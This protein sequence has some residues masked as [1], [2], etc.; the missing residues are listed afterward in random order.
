MSF[1]SCLLAM[2]WHCLPNATPTQVIFL[3]ISSLLVQT[4][5]QLVSSEYSFHTYCLTK[6]TMLFAHLRSCKYEMKFL[7]SHSCCGTLHVWLWI[8]SSKLGLQK[9]FTFFYWK[10]HCFMSAGAW[11]WKKKKSLISKHLRVS[12]LKCKWE[13]RAI[14]ASSLLWSKVSW[15]F[16]QWSQYAFFF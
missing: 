7:H 3:S 16:V 15:Y 12:E 4:C 9:C 13:I 8:M 10:L 5:L 11:I 1:P 14:M 2:K 6:N